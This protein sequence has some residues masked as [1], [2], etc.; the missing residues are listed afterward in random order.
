MRA[1]GG[2]P[3]TPTATPTS[4]RPT[5][6]SLD[7]GPATRWA[8]LRAP[9]AV[10]AL[11][12]LA[13]VLVAVLTA[14]GRGGV[15][16]PRSS[17]PEGSRALAEILRREGVTVELATTTAAAVAAAT[18]GTTL[19]VVNPDLLVPAQVDRLAGTAADLVL[20][21]PESR[22]VLEPLAPGVRPAAEAHGRRA[23][24]CDYGPAA[25]AGDETL[26]GIAYDSGAAGTGNVS[27]EPVST[28]R[29]TRCY[30]RG[31]AAPLIRLQPS[32][33]RSVVLL[34][35]PRILTNERLGE[36]GNAALALGLLGAR[37]RLTWYLPSLSDAAATG[38]RRSLWSLAPAGVRYGVAQT[39]LAVLV[40]AL[41]RGR[42]LGPIVEE[43]LPVVVRAAETIEGRA[44]LYRRVG[45]RG[46]AAAALRRAAVA[47]LLPALG[48][49]RRTPP[50]ALV[51]AAAAR[52]GRSPGEVNTLLY[53]PAP[54][55]DAALVGLAD[56]LD[57]LDREVRQP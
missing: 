46:S 4:A 3:V 20:S 49:P 29:V 10:A 2:P 8:R 6:T 52:T 27:P 44:R 25:R 28:T 5:V 18:Q 17:V 43:P 14:G 7:P 51:D 22:A 36:S 11:L 37:Q 1:R 16:D 26:G 33:G 50:P 39:A 31:S 57:R 54:T 24:G 56:S 32:T 15:L 41:W 42:R 48:L 40:L 9:L 47:R 35:D 23:P 53:G 13:G 21:R 19:L 30:A 45:A 38:G 34:G 12:L 55:T